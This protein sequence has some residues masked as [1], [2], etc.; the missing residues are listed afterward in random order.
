MAGSLMGESSDEPPARGDGDESDDG[1]VDDDHLDNKLIDGVFALRLA[2]EAHAKKTRAREAKALFWHDVYVFWTTALIAVPALVTVFAVAIGAAAAE[3]EGWSFENGY[4]YV[5]SML[6]DMPISLSDENPETK[7]GKATDIVAASW[8]WALLGAF[9]ALVGNL[10]SIKRLAAAVEGFRVVWE[11]FFL[12][13]CRVDRDADDGMEDLNAEESANIARVDALVESVDALVKK[14]A[15][16]DAAFVAAVR[17]KS[18]F[19][20]PAAA[21]DA[22][23]RREKRK[24]RRELSADVFTLVA[25]VFF[26]VPL[27]ALGFSWALGAVFAEIEGWRT[28]IGFYYV[29]SQ[30][31]SRKNV[32]RTGPTTELPTGGLYYLRP[33]TTDGKIFGVFIALLAWSLIG[34]FVGLIVNLNVISRFVRW[35]ESGGN[36]WRR[37]FKV[38]TPLEDFEGDASREDDVAMRD[39]ARTLGEI[40]AEMTSARAELLGLI[41]AAGMPKNKA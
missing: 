7:G 37:M 27:L 40:H 10:N 39:A 3:A 34:T 41:A 29:L 26:V 36:R 1:G 6:L 23:A 19:N 13:L 15:A 9:I 33:T 11:K 17:R 18:R 38:K 4:L 22:R 32:Y 35:L 2:D 31:F 12:C 8:A 30:A 25:G 14:R 16:A 21:R 28:K 24:D 5:F 20:L